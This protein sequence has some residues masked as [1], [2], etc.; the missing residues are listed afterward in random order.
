[1]SIGAAEKKAADEKAKYAEYHANLQAT[2]KAAEQAHRGQPVNEVQA[3]VNVA[4]AQ[5]K[6][7]YKGASPVSPAVNAAQVKAEADAAEQKAAE[8]AEAQRLSKL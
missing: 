2:T 8:V 4:E 1:M 6:A 7:Q 3:A 5:F